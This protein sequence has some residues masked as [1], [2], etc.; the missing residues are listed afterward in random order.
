MEKDFN[1]VK[2]FKSKKE[3][4][5]QKIMKS[6][7]EFYNK[8]LKKKQIIL[9][10]VCLIVFTILVSTF[11][12]QLSNGDIATQANNVSS[13]LSISRNDMLKSILKEKVP[14]AF[15][16]ILAGIVPYFYLPLLCIY[17]DPYMLAYDIAI[18]NKD[19]GG[20]IKML[21]ISI[22]SVL[23]L[24][25]FSLAIAIGIYYC[26]NCTKKYKYS[27]SKHIHFAD[28]KYRFYDL[29][30]DDKKKQEIVDKEQRL[31]EKKEKLNVKIDYKNMTVGLVISEIIVIL[32]SLISLI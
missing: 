20:V 19:T 17:F 26:K 9:Y 11:I 18:I 6:F 10:I 13:N 4:Y 27:Q 31:N 30:K 24:I 1:R 14:M 23:Q 16:T 5:F 2:K 28:I 15:L 22:S 3:G 7:F 29:K 12:A 21:P 32:S 8:N 25:G